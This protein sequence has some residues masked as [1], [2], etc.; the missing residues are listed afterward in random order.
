MRFNKGK[1]KV[2]TRVMATPAANTSRGTK[3]WSMA[4]VK[5]TWGC[6]WVAAGQEPAVHTHSPESPSYPGQHPKRA[7]S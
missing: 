7:G 5:S 1:C 4:L 6:W 2:C 3:G